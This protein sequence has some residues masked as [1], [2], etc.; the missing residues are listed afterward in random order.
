MEVF[1]EMYSSE[2]NSA[3][4]YTWAMENILGFSKSEIKLILKQKKVEKKIFAEIDASVET[5]KKI[6]LFKELDDRYELPGASPAG[7]SSSGEESSVG[8]GGGGAL[9]GL[10]NMELGSQLGGMEAGGGTP[11][12][13][14]ADEVGG[15]PE[16]GG[17]EE[18]P[19]AETRLKVIKKVLAESDRNTDD[20]LLD[21][22]GD[23]S[24]APTLAER[25][26]NENKLLH[27]NKKLNYKIEKM[28][29][30]IQSS[31]DD[32]KKE[33]REE[34]E[35]KFKESKAKNTLFERSGMVIDRTNSMFKNLEEMMNG[36]KVSGFDVDST[37]VINEEFIEEIELNEDSLD[38]SEGKTEE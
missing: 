11:D 8:G 27:K 18:A 20:L 7:A 34:N 14:G 2:S 35:K 28:I 1:K 17:A 37:E 10:G 12:M 31:L 19:L 5:Y 22:L 38:I 36:K 30:N 6:G 3:V 4:S 13:G 32:T 24:D 9:G 16:M 23:T 29:E 25:E 21:L 15:A 33:E 26:E